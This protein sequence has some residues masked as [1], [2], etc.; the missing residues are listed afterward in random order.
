MISSLQTKL[1]Q[2]NKVLVLVSTS[3]PCQKAVQYII[4]LRKE[5]DEENKIFE[6]DNFPAFLK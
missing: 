1:K 5:N 6:E 3:W 4:N 2:K